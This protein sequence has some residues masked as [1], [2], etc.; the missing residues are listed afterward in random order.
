MNG[1]GQVPQTNTD[2]VRRTTVG[3]GWTDPW[4]DAGLE[5]RG[6]GPVEARRVPE[7]A[8]RLLQESGAEVDR[9]AWDSNGRV[10]VMWKPDKTYNAVD[11]ANIARRIFAQAASGF[12]A[13]AR[14]I[15][16]RYRINNRLSSAQWVY[17]TND[18]IGASAPEIARRATP[19]DVAAAALPPAAAP[20]GPV[21][22]VVPTGEGALASKALL[23]VG[24]SVIAGTLV[25]MM[26]R[27][28]PASAG[29][30]AP[31][32][33]NRRASRRRYG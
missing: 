3:N 17:P 27:P 11:Y 25:Y 23:F 13:S 30:R 18:P 4:L 19:E 1:L 21:V 15:M 22:P 24:G 12:G 8:R 2:E 6:I 5:V 33:R 29:R 10:H 14:V 26:T 20:P 28:R 7:E 31:V 16:H 32:R 9:A